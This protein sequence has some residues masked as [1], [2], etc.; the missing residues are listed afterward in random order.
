[1]ASRRTT[2]G[3]VSQ[4]SRGP[5]RQSLA[6]ASVSRLDRRASAA[7]STFNSGRLSSMSSRRQ[8]TVPTR[9]G[10]RAS[11][12]MSYGSR[13]TDPRPLSDRAYRAAC[14]KDI[15]QFALDNGYAMPI[16]PKILTNPSSRDFQN[17]LLFLLRSLDPTFDFKKRFE[18]ELPVVLKAI[19]YPFTVSKSALTAVGSPH[20]WP[21]LLGVLTWLLENIKYKIAK[22]ETDDAAEAAALS[23]GAGDD[24]EMLH[25]SFS[26]DSE[27]HARCVQNIED[28]YGEFL[29]GAD[30]HPSLDAA[31]RHDVEALNAGLAERNA[32]LELRNAERTET[33]AAMKAQPPPL[34]QLAARKKTLVENTAKYN[35]LLPSQREHKAGVDRK[36]SD[37]V[38]EA[39]CWKAKIQALEKEVDEMRVVHS[40]QESK[41]I[42][43][44]RITKDR[45]LAKE[46]L[47]KLS[48]ELATADQNLARAEEALAETITSGEDLQRQYADKLSRIPASALSA[49]GVD[50]SLEF[51]A[52]T[53]TLSNDVENKI[54]PALRTLKESFNKQLAALENEELNLQEQIYVREERSMQ[55]GKSFLALQARCAHED[56]SYKAEKALMAKE[57]QANSED[58]GNVR[59]ELAERRRKADESLRVSERQVEII[60]QQ[61]H[62]LKGEIAVERTRLSRVVMHHVTNIRKHTA[63][64]TADNKAV[65]RHFAE[66]RAK[67]EAK[68]EAE[69]EA[70]GD[71]TIDNVSNAP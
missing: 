34:V 71:K 1:M 15:V 66:E 47:A 19:G 13:R 9:G 4:N 54:A 42:D 44:E 60:S 65:A 7:P 43:V 26:P 28:S 64:I 69:R 25:P 51:D 58:A 22:E 3:P 11:A 18:E 59:I 17:I 50:L 5:A 37:K 27:F 68:V 23:G 38:A 52:K 61:L 63:S 62:Q 57:I 6:P 35:M 70:E 31:Y 14:T 24:A 16:S 30:D 8:S 21:A 2:L 33:L 67:I 39:D 53:L 32:E 55:E 48:E 45:A 29:A 41:G 36:L 46:A 56:S 49:C 10:G 40:Q 12:S 20:S